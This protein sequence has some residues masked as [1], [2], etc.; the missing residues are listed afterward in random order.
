MPPTREGEEDPDELQVSIDTAACSELWC[1][2]GLD[3][4][5]RPVNWSF[6]VHSTCGCVCMPDCHFQSP[7]QFTSPLQRQLYLQPRG[8]GGIHA[9]KSSKGAASSPNAA[10]GVRNAFR[11]HQ[12][13]LCQHPA[14]QQIC[15][16]MI[17]L[18]ILS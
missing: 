6:A 2:L 11:D 1:V 8:A 10:A 14:A 7:S 15:T 9:P 5:S 4:P 13:R 18:V 12:Y 16:R 3:A 17:V